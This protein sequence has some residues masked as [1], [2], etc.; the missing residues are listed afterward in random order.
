MKHTRPIL[1]II[2]GALGAL[3]GLSGLLA[4]TPELSRSV[5]G[6]AGGVLTNTSS[7]LRSTVGQAVQ[8]KGTAASSFGYWGF[9]Y[10][11]E[12][13]ESEPEPGQWTEMAPMPNTPT[14]KPVKY[15]GWL[16]KGPDA[17]DDGDVIYA[18]KGHKTTDFY[19]FCP[20]EGELG[21]WHVLT[22][23]PADEEYKPGSV[24]T[25]P[26]KKGCKGVS[27]GAEAVY[28][29][30]GAN[31]SGFWRYDIDADT[32]GRMKDVPEGASGKRVKY[33]NDMV[34]V[35]TEDTGWIYLLKGYKT[36][37]FRYNTVSGD[38]DT[39]LPEVPWGTAPKYKAGSFLVYDGDNTIY[40]HQA[41]YYDK[42]VLPESDWHHSMFAF[43]IAANTWDTVTGMPILGLEKGSEDKKKK[44]KDGACGAWYDGNIYA[45]KGG[46][47]HSFWIYS[48]GSDAWDQLRED[49]LPQYTVT[50]DKA[51]RVKQGADIVHHGDGVFYA[52][53]G[54]KTRELWRYT[55][56]TADK[57]HET[58]DMARSGVM[59]AGVTNAEF[60]MTIAPNPV[61]SGFATVR[62]SLPKPGPVSV[63][64]YDV[65]GRRVL[66]RTLAG[67][68]G[69][70]A[71]P[72]DIRHLSGGVYLV[73]FDAGGRTTTQKLV[74]QR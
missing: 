30:R 32:W 3:G 27:D 44:S 23:I 7:G 4:Q 48:P 42:S 18:A 59:A 11:Q 31:M 14:D 1:C 36:E 64:L 29:T 58:K 5:I 2:L 8:G 6:A 15:G 52:L 22:D 50:T 25:K 39:T 56:G 26:G 71:V 28:M 10:S 16:A 17:T 38:W 51:R 24:K 70:A 69:S 21:T 63:T 13:A 20:T 9:W 41:N 45:F 37:F 66:T 35:F 57:E 62:Y 12:G 47:T 43:N 19:K 72:L 74:V 68:H 49:T 34:Y 33:G 61:G 46:N 54:N 55:A 40:A 67:G 53:K 73:R 65:S 60:R